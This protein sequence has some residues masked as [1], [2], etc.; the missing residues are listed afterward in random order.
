MSPELIA[1]LAVIAVAM[2]FD[3]TNGFHDAANAI[4]TSISTRALTPRIAL[5]L[6]AVGNFVGA[7]FGAGVAK[8]VGDGLVTLPT[9]VESLGVVF[10][11]VLGAIIWNLITWYFGLPSSSS[12]ALFGGLVGATLFAA[13]GIVQWGTII[14]KVLIPMVLSP[15]VGLVLGFLVM[16]AIMW[17]FR[18]GQPGKLSRGFRWAQTA[19]AAAMS[20][21]HGMQDAAKTMGIIVLALYTGGFQESKTHIPG[22]VFWTSA[23]MLAAGT[24]AG[25]WRIIRTLGR[26]I[27]DLGPAEGFAAETVASAVL[28]FNAL[29]LKAPIS[30]THTIT[31]AIMGVGATKRLSAVRWN[32]AGNIVIAWI[33]TFP[34]AAAIACLAYLLVRPLF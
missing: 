8:T 15:V 2:A 27:I 33:I 12:H 28:Y 18:K 13:D 20:V 22:W 6:A 19:S 7:H 16:L 4:A 23:A 24:Y 17:L 5:A 31:S 32:V 10:A 29:V 1:V 34:A 25:G 26:K 3:Y 11:G 9:G 14:E 30:T 21:G